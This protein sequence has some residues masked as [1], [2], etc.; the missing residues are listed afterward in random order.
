MPMVI[1][2]SSGGGGGKGTS[3]PPTDQSD[4]GKALIV[5]A[6]GDIEWGTISGSNGDVPL[7]YIIALS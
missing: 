7:D 6:S 1:K 4:A 3:L 2:P 5:N